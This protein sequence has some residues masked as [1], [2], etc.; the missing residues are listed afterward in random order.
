MNH[1][2]VSLHLN[3]S[4]NTYHDTLVY[5]YFLTALIQRN[6]CFS[7]CLPFVNDVLF[8]QNLTLTSITVPLFM[9]SVSQQE[10]CEKAYFKMDNVLIDDR[11]I[12]VDFSQ[13]VAKIRWKGKGTETLSISLFYSEGCYRPPHLES[14]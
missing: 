6:L 2:H 4:F 1:C 13:S 3:Y 12:H 7:Q 8:L 10:D 9:L 5:L 14:I 11:R